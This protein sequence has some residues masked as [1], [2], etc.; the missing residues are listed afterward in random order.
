MKSLDLK[1]Q[2]M[3]N[4]LENLMPFINRHNEDRKALDRLQ[5]K[6][7]KDYQALVSLCQA[8]EISELELRSHLNEH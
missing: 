5:K 2:V 7:Y 6:V 8:F 1:E 4:N 3:S